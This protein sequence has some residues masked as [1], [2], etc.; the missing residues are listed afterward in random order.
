[1]KARKLRT[2]QEVREDFIRRGISVS[3]WAR[4][5]GFS[6]NQV[7]AVVRG[8]CKCQYGQAHKIAVLLGIKDGEIV[9]G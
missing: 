8:D 7:N 1:M 3:S 4:E 9:E 5:H 2:P 6:R